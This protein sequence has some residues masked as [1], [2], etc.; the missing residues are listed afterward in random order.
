MLSSLPNSFLP[1]TSTLILKFSIEVHNIT[2]SSYDAFYM[3]FCVNYCLR[4]NHQVIT[5]WQQQNGMDWK[6]SCRFTFIEILKQCALICLDVKVSSTRLMCQYVYLNATKMLKHPQI[7]LP[8]GAVWYAGTEN[9]D[10]GNSPTSVRKPLKGGIKQKCLLRF[11]R[12]LCFGLV[13]GLCVGKCQIVVF[14]EMS[15]RSVQ[16]ITCN[17]N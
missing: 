9:S 11:S 13:R 1:T 14:S 12:V 5:Y 10:R 8:S 4:N 2:A 16:A 15:A 6:P 3:F 7:N 17:S